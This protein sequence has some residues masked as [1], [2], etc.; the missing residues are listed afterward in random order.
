MQPRPLA[1]A[2]LRHA[3]QDAH[4]RRALRRRGMALREVRYIRLPS[5]LALPRARCMRPP[6]P[7][8]RR[9]AHG[10]RDRDRDLR[11]RLGK[12]RREDLR[13][14]EAVRER[15]PLV[16]LRV[17]VG[18]RRRLALL[19]V[20]VRVLP[21]P[22][23]H[24][25]RVRVA[26]V[27]ERRL[28]VPAA[29]RDELCVEVGR[30]GREGSRERWRGDG[31]ALGR[32]WERRGGLGLVSGLF[33]DRTREEDLQMSGFSREQVRTRRPETY[34]E[35][36]RSRHKTSNTGY[37]LQKVCILLSAPLRSCQSDAPHLSRTYAPNS[38]QRT[39]A[40]NKRDDSQAVVHGMPRPDDPIERQDHQR[41]R[42]HEPKHHACE[43]PTK[44]TSQP[45]ST[46]SDNT[47]RATT[48]SDA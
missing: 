5:A 36:D 40:R 32:V 37:H 48:Q 15:V 31:R 43:L 4:T 20:Y 7:A 6:A 14:R 1:I 39:G 44:P 23:V 16:Q 26:C 17:R 45:S 34:E 10:G 3:R 9:V 18:V 28:A 19:A 24:L 2:L 33:Y 29:W 12:H 25:V 35:R 11:R 8:G 47:Y 13:A 41:E 46:E 42:E 38:V 27:V 22:V 21:V 30:R